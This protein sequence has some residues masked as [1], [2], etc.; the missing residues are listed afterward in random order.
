MNVSP[1]ST[2][3]NEIAQNDVYAAISDARERNIPLHVI[4]LNFDGNLAVEYIENVAHSTGG[5]F[6]ETADASDIPQ[7]IAA[8]FNEMIAAPQI[9]IEETQTEEDEI[10]APVEII[11]EEIPP[12]ELA[13]KC[14]LFESHSQ[15]SNNFFAAAT[16]SAIFA[17][18]GTLLIAKKLAP[19]RVFTGK[20]VLEKIDLQSRKTSRAKTKNLIEFGSRVSLAALLGEN[21]H[22]QFESVTLVPSPTAPSHL[23]HL[24]IKCK[25]RNIKFT[26]DFLQ[27][28]IA[29]GFPICIGTEFFIENESEQV[30]IKYTM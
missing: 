14:T 19:K 21:S 2:R 23:P 28:D 17:G 5:L 16:G 13:T 25:H 27:H 24:Q 9:Q 15:Y 10:F 29:N 7:I 3:T 26:K 30:R 18:L 1:H 22:T 4:G 8:F 20:I 11:E 6:F 12:Q